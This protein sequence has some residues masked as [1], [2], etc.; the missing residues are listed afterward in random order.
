MQLHLHINGK[1]GKIKIID[2]IHGMPKTGEGWD[3]KAL[4]LKEQIFQLKHE[5]ITKIYDQPYE[6]YLVGNSSM[7]EDKLSE[8]HQEAWDKKFCKIKVVR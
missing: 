2:Y 7:R 3:Y 6:I 4:M 8:E 1:P 5:Q